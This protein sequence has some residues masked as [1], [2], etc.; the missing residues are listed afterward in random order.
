[1]D[2]A[3]LQVHLGAPAPDENHPGDT[4]ASSRKP[5]DVV[6]ELLGEIALAG[7]GLHVRPVELLDVGLIEDGRPGLHRLEL[8]AHLIEQPAPQ[9]LGVAGGLVAVVLED[10]PAA[11]DEVVE[12]GERD[13][14]P[15]QGRAP[16]GP[17]AETDRA[18]LRERPGRRGE[19]LANRVNT[20][21]EGRADG[22][23]TSE[24][25]PEAPRGRSD[26]AGALHRRM[27]ISWWSGVFGFSRTGAVGRVAATRKPGAP[28]APRADGQG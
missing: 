21:D 7:A 17:L 10:V 8:R 12:R 16:V 1:M 9:H 28:R 3:L 15:D 27:T 19:S 14:I 11:E 22:A 20:G 23:E 5:A 2:G 26:L 13:E 18:H 6:A 24:Q 25:N 4:P